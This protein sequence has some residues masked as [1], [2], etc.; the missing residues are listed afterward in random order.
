VMILNPF[1]TDRAV[2]SE[3]SAG[4]HAGATR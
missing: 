2:S 4:F 3:D 1:E